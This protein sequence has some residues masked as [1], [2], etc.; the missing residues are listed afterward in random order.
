MCDVKARDERPPSGSKG[1]IEDAEAYCAAH[2]LRFTDARRRVLELLLEAPK[3]VGAYELLDHLRR[4]KLGAQ[5]PA[6]YRALDFLVAHGFV[7]KIDRLSAFVACTHPHEKH[8]PVFMVCKRCDSVT[9]ICSTR[10]TGFLD[11]AAGEMGF[12]LEETVVEAFGTCTSCKR[13]EHPA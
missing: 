13:G 5:P 7:H 4:E 3:A 8:K 11:M 9:E 12:E 1:V 2:G 10:S 6:V